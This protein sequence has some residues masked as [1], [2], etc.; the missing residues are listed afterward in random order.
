MT[1]DMRQ[2]KAAESRQDG[3]WPA[4]GKDHS[5]E[6]LL[7]VWTLGWSVNLL[8]FHRELADEGRVL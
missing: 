4:E 6:T 8:R 3:R 1:G 2:G 5:L 7:K